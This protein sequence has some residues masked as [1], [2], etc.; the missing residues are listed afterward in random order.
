MSLLAVIEA[1]H[2]LVPRVLTSNASK[3]CR[4]IFDPYSTG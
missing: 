3:T 2:P 1:T 4:M